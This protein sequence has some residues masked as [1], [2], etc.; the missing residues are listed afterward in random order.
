MYSFKL[1]NGK[2]LL[3]YRIYS[4]M[5][6]IIIT[7]VFSSVSDSFPLNYRG[8]LVLYFRINYLAFNL[9]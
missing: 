4:I 2:I 8:N 1:K 3:F 9:I 7:H 6:I 5:K